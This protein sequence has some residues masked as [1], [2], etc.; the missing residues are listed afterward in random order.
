MV[1]RFVPSTPTRVPGALRSFSAA[2]PTRS[3]WIEG[4]ASSVSVPRAS[5]SPSGV[6]VA[7]SA[8]PPSIQGSN[9]LDIL[10]TSSSGVVNEHPSDSTF[11][12]PS[13]LSS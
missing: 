2:T 12:T 7:I 4:N 5:S 1:V 6:E 9:V 3:I 8:S 10:S 13:G 11:S